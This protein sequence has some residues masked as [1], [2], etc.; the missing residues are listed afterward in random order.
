MAD[1]SWIVIHDATKGVDAYAMECLG[2]GE[3]QRFALL[4]NLDMYLAAARVF[5]RNHR[6]CASRFRRKAG[7][8]GTP[9]LSSS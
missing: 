3:K 6:R 8:S 4:I 2:C 7:Q 9:N 1:R 5:E